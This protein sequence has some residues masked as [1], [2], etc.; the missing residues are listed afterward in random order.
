M[1]GNTKVCRTRT[2]VCWWNTTNIPHRSTRQSIAKKFIERFNFGNAHPSII[3]METNTRL[4]VVDTDMKQRKQIPANG[5]NFP[6][7]ELVGSLIT[8]E[9]QKESLVQQSILTVDGYCDSDWGNDPDT[10]KSVTGFVHCIAGGQGLRNV[11]LQVFSNVKPIFRM[12]VDNQAAYVMVTNPTYSRRERHIELRWHYVRDQ[13]AKG[14]WSYRK[15][16]LTEIHQ[17]S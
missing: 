14:M 16:R 1:G 5:K 6:Y 9:P 10:R 8:S 15:S 3:P 17:T 4:T 2:W 12:G 7:R 11:L 13:V